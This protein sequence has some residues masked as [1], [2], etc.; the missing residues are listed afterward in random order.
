MFRGVAR[1]A[2]GGPTDYNL[3]VKGVKI[4]IFWPENDAKFH[5]IARFFAVFL[6]K[7]QPEIAKCRVGE[8][9]AILPLARG[10][11]RT[12]FLRRRQSV[13]PAL[14]RIRYARAKS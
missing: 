10:G 1:T 2:S 4:D 6:A 12:G 11:E 8:S 3:K 9:P 14:S 13:V 5:G 7:T